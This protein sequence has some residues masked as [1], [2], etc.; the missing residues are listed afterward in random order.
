MLITYSFFIVTQTDIGVSLSNI[1]TTSTGF[2]YKRRQSTTIVVRARQ[3]T[4][5]CSVS[6][7]GRCLPISALG[8]QEPSTNQRNGNYNN[9]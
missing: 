2:D 6:Q 8:S 9:A 4:A 1:Q 3:T 5:I 7:P